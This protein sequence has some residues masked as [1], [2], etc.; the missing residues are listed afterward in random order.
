MFK[1]KFGQESA[2][3]WSLEACST[4]STFLVGKTLY[5][6]LGQCW[7]QI[8]E[9]DLNLAEDQFPSTNCLW[10]TLLT[11]LGTSGVRELILKDRAPDPALE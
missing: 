7:E 10:L 2:C 4:P 11:R 1:Q 8:K 3:G 6:R 9:K 5:L